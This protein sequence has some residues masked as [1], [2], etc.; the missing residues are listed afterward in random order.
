MENLDYGV[1]RLSVLSVRAE[2]S[3]KAEQTTQLLF[4]DHYEVIDRSKDNKWLRIR[5]YFDQY[6]GWIDALQHHAVSKDYIEYLE[7]SELKITTDLTSSLLYNKSPLAI[8]MGSMIP[9][10]SSELFKMEEQFAF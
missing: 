8:L 7:K 2:P 5:I 6:E 10:S 1:C 9:I 3:D 4:G